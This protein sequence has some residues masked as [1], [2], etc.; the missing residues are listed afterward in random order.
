MVVSVV[1]LPPQ[2]AESACAAAC[3]LVGMY[4][5]TYVCMYVHIHSDV[6]I[7][8][9]GHCGSIHKYTHTYMQTY[10][11]TYIW[12]DAYT[13][14]QPSVQP[15]AHETTPHYPTQ[16]AARKKGGRASKSGRMGMHLSVVWG[17][18]GG[19][20]TRRAARCEPGSTD[21]LFCTA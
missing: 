4:V 1:Q 12:M 6:F 21:T 13:A 5:C 8:I 2:F 18:W 9:Q 17:R 14:E 16:T 20:L 11:H 19:D 15:K 10:I 7:Q 3:M